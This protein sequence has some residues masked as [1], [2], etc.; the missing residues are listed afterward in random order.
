MADR[1]GMVGYRREPRRRQIPPSADG[2]EHI[3]A[4]HG[5]V[6]AA[7]G[8]RAG[9]P[10]K[11]RFIVR[12]QVAA[13]PR[14]QN[15]HSQLLGERQE[16]RRAAGHAYAAAREDYGAPRGDEHRCDTLEMRHRGR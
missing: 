6:G 5:E 16:L 12:N 9:P 3:S 8:K 7:W 1:P 4:L 10:R 2:Q 14:R 13:H 15:R 11:K